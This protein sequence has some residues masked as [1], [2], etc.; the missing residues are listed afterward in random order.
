MDPMQERVDREL[1]EITSK[2]GITPKQAKCLP[3]VML[4]AVQ[5]LKCSME[6][7]VELCLTNNAFRANLAKMCRTTADYLAEKERG[8]TILPTDN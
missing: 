8:P 1:A 6:N 3:A 5:D 7:V 4:V 2:M